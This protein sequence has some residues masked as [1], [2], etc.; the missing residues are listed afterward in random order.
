MTTHHLTAA[1]V[2]RYQAEGYLSP[3]PALDPELARATLAKVEAY[4]AQH[5]EFPSKGLKAHL[6]LPWM[7]RVVRH[8][9]ILDAVES[10]VGPDILCWSSRFFIKD[11]ATA[12]SCRGT[13]TS[14][15]GDST[16]RRIF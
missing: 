14:P 13:R 16:F 11:R 8:P 1:Q 10:I 4:E 5:G 3:L 2:A 6:Y 15:T 7:E 12:A 9:A